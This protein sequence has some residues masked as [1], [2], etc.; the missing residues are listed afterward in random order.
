MTSLI[1]HRVNSLD[2]YRKA[3]KDKS[4]GIESDVQLTKDNVPVL[5]HD[6]SV[7]GID[8]EDVLFN[9]ISKINNPDDATGKTNIISLNEFLSGTIAEGVTDE[10]RFTMELK[11]ESLGLSQK[12]LDVFK[13]NGLTDRLTVSSFFPRH[14]QEVS[15]IKKQDPENYG[16]VKT[17]INIGMNQ[18]RGKHSFPSEFHVDDVSQ[19]KKAM[20]EFG[21]SPDIF[22]PDYRLIPNKEALIELSGGSRQKEVVAWTVN[23]PVIA[24][25]LSKIGADGIITDKVK[26]LGMQKSVETSLHM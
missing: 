4:Q 14:L 11:G 5:Y 12:V 15:N 18:Y 7:N 3:L 24:D 22:S 2:G 19:V 25:H 26:E 8:I 9:D 13:D 10:M 1:S 23:F 20:G 17:A 21:I 16:D 6:P